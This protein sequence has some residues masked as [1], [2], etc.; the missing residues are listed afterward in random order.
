MLFSGPCEMLSCGINAECNPHDPPR[1]VCRPGFTG[2]PLLGCIDIDECVNSPCVAGA[3][4]INEHGSYR[5][6]CP[7]GVT[8]EGCK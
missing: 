4:C 8:G 7:K 5:C 2:D 3:K 6:D 1:C